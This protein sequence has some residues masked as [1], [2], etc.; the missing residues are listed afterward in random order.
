MVYSK[1][2]SLSV[3]KRVYIYPLMPSMSVKIDD[4][5][6]FLHVINEFI[7]RNIYNRAGCTA[8]CGGPDHSVRC[9]LNH[10]GISY[11]VAQSVAHLF[12]SGRK[13]HQYYSLLVAH[14]F[15]SGRTLI[16]FWSQKVALLFT[17]GR[18]HILQHPVTQ[19]VTSTFKVY[20]N[21]S[22]VSNKILDNFSKVIG[23]SFDCSW[24]I[25]SFRLPGLRLHSSRDSYQ[26]NDNCIYD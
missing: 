26:L 2:Y 24:S 20:I 15:T 5:S 25:D 9:R 8:L 23:T 10:I 19:D 4:K 22:K 16:H 13:K 12:T 18:G 11:S 7:A 6:G 17:F 14:L 21:F 3:E 1:K